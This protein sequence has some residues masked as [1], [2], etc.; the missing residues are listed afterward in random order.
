MAE[1]RNPSSAALA[2]ELRRNPLAAVERAVTEGVPGEDDRARGYDLL[3]TDMKEELSGE[4]T[5]LGGDGE[6][7]TNAGGDAAANAATEAARDGAASAADDDAVGAR[8]A[9][10]GG[11][12]EATAFSGAGT[13]AGSAREES[14]LTD[15][16]VPSEAVDAG[17][18]ASGLGAAGGGRPGA[19]IR[20]G[21]GAAPGDA[22]TAPVPAVE[23]SDD[24]TSSGT[25]ADTV[26]DV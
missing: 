1:N 4:A 24:G 3:H 10:V 16:P 26:E 20:G 5:L 17:I 7:S 14:V 12:G 19:E 2:A 6:D 9:P 22:E 11:A 8:A 21:G 25:D 23:G 15:I 13:P 18:D